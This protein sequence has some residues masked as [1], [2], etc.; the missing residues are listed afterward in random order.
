MKNL[1]NKQKGGAILTLIILLLLG[2]GI[3]IGIQYVPQMIESK[4][5]ESIFDTMRTDQAVDPVQ[6]EGAAKA[7]VIRLLQINEMNEM[8]KNIKTSRG[9]GT[10]NV[11]VSYDRELNLGFK[12]HPMHYEKNLELKK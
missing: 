1:P 5:V 12:V 11:N 4:A 2:Y 8:T 6:T 9:A 7:K 10:I 3:W